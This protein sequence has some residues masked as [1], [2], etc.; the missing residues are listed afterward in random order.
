MLFRSFDLDITDFPKT[1][2][3]LSKFTIIK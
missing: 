2:P 1:Y 3:I